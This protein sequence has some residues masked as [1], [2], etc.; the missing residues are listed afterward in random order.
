MKLIKDIGYMYD[1]EDIYPY[2]NYMGKVTPKTKMG[3][4]KVILV[5]A[6]NPTKY[7]EGKTTVAI[8]LS[9]AI[10]IAGKKAIV[11][12]REPSMGPVFG[13][14]GGAVGGGKSLI[15]P[16]NE[17]NLHFTGDFHAITTANNLIAAH[18][19]NEI[20]ND[21]GLHLKEV[22]FKRC[23][24][25][26]DRV[27]RD[28]SVLGRKDSFEITAASEIMSV[29]MIS[30]DLDDLRYR[31]NNIIIGYNENL[32]EVYLSS[33]NITDA[34]IGILEQAFKPNLVQTLGGYGALVHTGPFANISLGCSSLVSLETATNMAD[35]V[36]T[37][38]GFGADAGAF[39]FI[40]ILTRDNKI[41]LACIVL[42]TTV[43]ALKYNGDGDLSVGIENLKAHVNNLKLMNEN[44]IVTINKFND[45]TKEDIDYIKNVCLEL[46]VDAEVNTSFEDGGAGVLDLASKVIALSEKKNHIRYIYDLE[47][48][49]YDKIDAYVKKI[50]HADGFT[51]SFDVMKKLN[52]LDKYKYPICVAKTQYSLSDNK[53]LLG[54]PKGF[55]MTLTDIKVSN[56]TKTII[57]YFGNILT[58]PG[59][60]N[61]PLSKEFKYVNGKLIIPR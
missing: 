60:P 52:E 7:G 24:D 38:A 17:I 29:M 33:L 46:G 9:D 32:S 28:V 25:L 20:Y 4:G 14:K 56:G 45:D 54:F 16:E 43:R 27:L 36:V 18:I 58:M 55:R 21:N 31:L 19:D 57:C 13:L 47:D 44:L 2:G 35:Y 8:G 49:L 48:T 15:L 1:V 51:C 12:L 37:E 39:K 34:L 53:K 11:N 30:K 3:K 6:T 22:T 42:V 40:D 41:N 23:I 59:L 26:N 10:N 5:T 61:E 50:C